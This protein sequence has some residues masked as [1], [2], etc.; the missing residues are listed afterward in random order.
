VQFQSHLAFGLS[1]HPSR[2]GPLGIKPGQHAN[3]AVVHEEL[4]DTLNTHV[5][6][7]G[8]RREIGMGMILA[9][10]SEWS[11]FRFALP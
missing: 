11:I 8:D 7:G 1:Y 2:N 4:P 10:E 3:T 9:R 5:I 6:H